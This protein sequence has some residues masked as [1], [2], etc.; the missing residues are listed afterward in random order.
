[1]SVETLNIIECCSPHNGEKV[2]AR[3]GTTLKT[4]HKTLFVWL[5]R[6]KSRKSLAYLSDHMLKDVGL[7]KAQV[8]AEIAKPFWVR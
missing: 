3:L 7:T 8:E 5:H 4:V 6:H 1:M 2:Q